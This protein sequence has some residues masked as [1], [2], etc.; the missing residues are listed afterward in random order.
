MRPDIIVSVIVANFNGEKFLLEALTSAHHQTLQDIEIIVIDDASTD[1]SVAIAN[2]FAS[3]DHR[4]RVI[5][6][7][8]RSGPGSA[9]NDGLA[10]AR[11]RWIAILDSDDMMHPS[12][13]EALVREAE[14]SGA[15][16]CADDLLVFQNGAAPSSHLSRRQRSFGWIPVTKFV[17]RIYSRE[18]S[19][20]YLKPLIRTELLRRHGIRYKPD[21]LIGEDYDLIIQL[22]AKGARFRLLDALGYFYRKHDQ[23]I[24]HRLS[25]KNLEHMTDADQSLRHLFAEDAHDVARAFDARRASIERA[26]AFSTIISAL[27][28]RKWMEAS[29]I[30]AKNPSAVPLLA[31]PL[32]AK[33]R[34]IWRPRRRSVAVDGDSWICIV[35]GD[36]LIKNSEA[37]LAYLAVITTTLRDSGYRTTL[38]V[39]KTL[40]NGLHPTLR[41]PREFGALNDVHIRG[42]WKIGRRL[43]IAGVGH[44]LSA[45]VSAIMGHLT[46]KRD[47]TPPS[48]S[49][50]LWSREEQLYIASKAPKSC[51]LVVADGTCAVSALPYTLAPLALSAIFLDERPLGAGQFP[52][53]DPESQVPQALRQLA[54]DNNMLIARIDELLLPTLRLPKAQP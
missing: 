36:S 33:L 42:T 27:K 40:S 15:D 21:L 6:R 3:K 37:K 22:L 23:S 7:E 54:L 53:G 30:A 11:G 13:L 34:S 29:A 25:V 1:S 31:L 50:E 2:Q 41:L 32:I 16:I 39:P 4:I 19:L 20:G 52:H 24:S 8:V 48:S 18:P 10:V 5:A 44:L 46:Q 47:P 26:I 49:H 38:I 45:A 51:A 28:A 43:R 35:S 17:D 12:R 14:A 9:R